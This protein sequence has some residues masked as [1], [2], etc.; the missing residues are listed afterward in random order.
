MYLWALE[1]EGRQPFMEDIR[2]RMFREFLQ[3]MAWWILVLSAQD[4][5][6]II[7][8]LEEL[9]FGRELIKFL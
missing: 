8:T 7:I 6:G 3:S 5:L 2:S 1:E 4:L 9:E